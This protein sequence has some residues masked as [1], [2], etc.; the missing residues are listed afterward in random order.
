MP[1][2][3]RSTERMALIAGMWLAA[4]SIASA[5]SIQWRRDW[6]SALNEA[7]TTGK[8]IFLSV[9]AEWC[10]FCHKMERETFSQTPVAQKINTDFIP[11]LIDAD[12]NPEMLQWAGVRAFPSTVIISP[13]QRV[14]SVI[15]GYKLADP[16]LACLEPYRAAPQP[17]ETIVAK[18]AAPAVQFASATSEIAFGGHCMVCMLEEQALAKGK[19]VFEADHEGRTFRFYCEGC[20]TKFLA[21][22]A[23]YL[24]V[25]GGRCIVNGTAGEPKHATVYD[26]KIYFTA[27][28]AARNAFIANPEKFLLLAK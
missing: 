9:T 8:P 20:R 1:S 26:G 16:L 3:L 6:E 13:E 11:Y 22:P 12:D 4:I 14:L 24:P 7:K 19:P 27:D 28:A 18:P 2:F 23:K 15:K 5:D 10:H 17:T 21:N 25:N